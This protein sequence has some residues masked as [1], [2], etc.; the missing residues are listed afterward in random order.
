MV[1]CAFWKVLLIPIFAGL[2]LISHLVTHW[3]KFDR[4]EFN[5]FA[6]STGLSTIT[7]RLV[8]SAINRI[9]EF[10]FSSISLIC[11]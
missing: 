7:Y 10:M 8:S 4:S 9:D 3:W 6:A 1:C 5:W 11:K 2:N